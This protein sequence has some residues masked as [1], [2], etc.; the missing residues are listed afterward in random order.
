MKTLFF[1]CLFVQSAYTTPSGVVHHPAPKEPVY[2]KS[3]WYPTLK[4]T[5]APLPSKGSPQQKLDEEE[6]LKFQKSRSQADCEQAKI[7]VFVSLQNFFGA[8]NGP[9]S[10]STARKLTPFFEQLRNDGDY[11]IQRLKKDYPRQRPFLYISGLEP[12]VP[13]EVTGAYPSG[14]AVLSKLFAL[15]LT[16][17]FPNQKEV[18]ETRAKL[19]ADHRILSGMHHRSDIDAGRQL[20]TLIYEE[21]KKSPKYQSDFKR[22][23]VQL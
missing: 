5:L 6:L 16:D 7:E 11:F 1:L 23:Q 14:H 10:E 9:I 3:D 17:M 12:C 20:A 13:R 18:L 8:P 22:L 21:L 19:I 15:V 4:K 2:V